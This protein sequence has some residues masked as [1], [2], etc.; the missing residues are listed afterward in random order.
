MAIN[1]INCIK[2]EYSSAVVQTQKNTAADKKDNTGMTSSASFNGF[3]S[4]ML[5]GVFTDKYKFSS[6]QE[7]S[8]YKE[9]AESL[10]G[11]DKTNFDIL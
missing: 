10:Q 6:A 11:K 8:M 3:F 7:K 9:L 2:P 5:P 4:D 1:P